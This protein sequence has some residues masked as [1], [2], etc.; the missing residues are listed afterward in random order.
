MPES[1]RK[2][3]TVMKVC[4]ITTGATAK[5]PE[6]IQAALAPDCLQSFVDNGF[7]HLNF[8]C[9]ESFNSFDDFKP[10]DTKGLDIQ[11]FDFNKSGLN[12]EMRA[13]QGKA[14]VSDKGLLICHAGMFFE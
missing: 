10:A 9:G 7:T 6:L 1:N 8:Q 2:N 14:G 13:C 11:A 4:L 12:K 5:F 3:A